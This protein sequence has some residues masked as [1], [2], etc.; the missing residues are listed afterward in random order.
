M[1]A[2]MREVAAEVVLPR[3]RRLAADEIVEK[4]PGDIVTI[5]DREAEALLTKRLA[6]IVPG[7]IVIGEEAVSADPSLMRR[8]AG[9]S[10]VWLV[11]PVDGTTNFAA[12]RLP[13]AM[14]VALLREGTTVAAWIL[15]P[16]S[17]IA[18]TAE[19]GAGGFLAGERAAT[20]PDGRPAAQLRGPASATYLPPDVRAA[21]AAAGHTVGAVLPGRFCAGAE[22]P[23]L[24]RDEQQ[25]AFFWRLFPWDHAPG[26][27]FVEECGGMARH[28]D[29]RPYEPTRPGVGVLTAQN[30]EVWHTV[31]TTLFAAVPG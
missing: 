30:A 25:F 13:F 15:D 1:D 31:R 11:D 18:A 20:P 23:A 6:E 8:L 7:S 26:I 29:G 3:F 21:I 12:G 14:M 2:L 10:A 16:V 28:L 17:G 19:R 27:L 24:V 4:A 5:A 22:Y 9:A